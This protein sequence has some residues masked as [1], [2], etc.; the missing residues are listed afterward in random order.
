MANKKQSD[1]SKAALEI[2]GTTAE[3]FAPNVSYLNR[4]GFAHEVAQGSL[5]LSSDHASYITG[6]CLPIDGGFMAK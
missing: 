4:F 5:W 1:M 6:I 2:M 3:E